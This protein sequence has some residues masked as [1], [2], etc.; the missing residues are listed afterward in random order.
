MVVHGFHPWLFKIGP[1]VAGPSKNEN[2]SH[3]IN[4]LILIIL[5][6]LFLKLIRH[7]GSNHE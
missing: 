5:S 6:G 3:L 2:S 7:S 1:D 4:I